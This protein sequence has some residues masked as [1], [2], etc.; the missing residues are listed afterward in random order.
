MNESVVNFSIFSICMKTNF[1]FFLLLAI[2]LINAL[3]VSAQLSGKVIAIADGDTFTLLT[4]D[5]QQIKIRLHGID[6]PE[7]KQP[8][9]N[10][11]TAFTSNKVFGKK[12]MVKDMGKD[13]YKRTIG[14]VICDDGTNLNEA[15]LQAGLAWHFRKYDTNASWANMERDARAAKKGLWVDPNPIAPWDWRKKK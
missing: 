3:L 1:R 8:Y 15:L 7:K 11:A 14:M 4:N 10:N 5:N 12:V 13:R 2:G 9:S 6:C